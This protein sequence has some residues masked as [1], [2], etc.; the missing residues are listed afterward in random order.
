MNTDTPQTPQL[1]QNAVKCRFF[2]QY[3]GQFYEFK[4]TKTTWRINEGAFPLEKEGNERLILTD[5]KNIT[6]EDAI[7]VAKIFGMTEDFEFIG[8]ILCNTIFDNSDSESET[9][10]YNSNAKA[11]DYLRSKGYA[12]PFME[13]SVKDLVSFDWVRLV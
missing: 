3:W 11:V 7:D 2:A 6:N 13:Y 10:I 5:L 8:K 12:L 9:T 4:N 1:P